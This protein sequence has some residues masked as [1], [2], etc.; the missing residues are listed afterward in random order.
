M[1]PSLTDAPRILPAAVLAFALLGALSW[2]GWRAVTQ[3]R[4][5]P[6]TA[7]PAQALSPQPQAV[8]SSSAVRP[9]R[10]PEPAETG[11]P[12]WDELTVAQKEALEPL[13][14]RWPVLS[15]PQKRHWLNLAASFRSLSHEE[16]HKMVERMTEWANL[17]IQQR[18]QARFNYAATARLTSD[19][20]RAK[21]EA[22]QAL[23][24]EEKHRLA[25]HAA[26]KP[27]GAATA[28]RPSAARKLAKVPAATAAAA[29]SA[30][31]PNLPKIPRVNEAH[32]LQALPVPTA[33]PMMPASASGAGVETAPVSM[34]A[35]AVVTPLPPGG[36][37]AATAASQA[38][39][40]ARDLTPLHPPQ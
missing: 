30:N 22:Y 6:G 17:S 20:K 12:S 36:A 2:G 25:A 18:N 3:V 28:L 38:E 39:P 27:A 37:A 23:S 21:W 7:I 9:V 5:A 19:S 4:M 33:W 24:P 31:T 8:R 34:P 14:E 10:V 15:E 26:P 13:N 35:A 40:L 1:P 11:G 16:R 32:A 29:K